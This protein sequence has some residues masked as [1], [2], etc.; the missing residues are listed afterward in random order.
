MHC[1]DKAD[2]AK[3]YVDRLLKIN[4]QSSEGLAL[5]GW[6]EVRYL[7]NNYLLLFWYVIWDS[8]RRMPDCQGQPKFIMWL[9][10]GQLNLKGETS[11]LV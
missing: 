7:Q 9:S 4:P 10:V 8:Q 2:K 3:E 5:K 6:V 1:I 11:L